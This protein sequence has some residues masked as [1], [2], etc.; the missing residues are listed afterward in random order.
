MVERM[1][2]RGLWL[3]STGTMLVFMTI[4]TALSATFVKTG[5]AAVGGA[6]VAFLFLFF[7]GEFCLACT[8]SSWW[9]VIDEIRI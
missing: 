9:S 3:T 1:G 8:P 4:V 6:T 5:S 2:R 7:A